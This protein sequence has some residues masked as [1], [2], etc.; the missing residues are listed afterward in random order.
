MAADGNVDFSMN[1]IIVG[2]IIKFTDV[3]LIEEIIIL[4]NMLR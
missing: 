4:L 1:M 3:Y 2:G